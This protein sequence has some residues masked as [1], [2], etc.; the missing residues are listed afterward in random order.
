MKN[1]VDVLLN[2]EEFG[3]ISSAVGKGKKQYVLG[4]SSTQKAFYLAGIIKACNK[5]MFVVCENQTAQEKL[6]ADL[7]SFLDQNK[8]FSL[9]NLD[10]LPYGDVGIGADL[11]VARAKAIKAI[12]DEEVGIVVTCCRALMDR[13]APKEVLAAN[14]V[15]LKVGDEVD[16]TKLTMKLSKAGYER[17]QKAEGRGQMSVKGG[18]LDV[19]SQDSDA[20][21]RIE[22]Y[23]DEI[24][25]IR[26]YDKDTQRSLGNLEVAQIFLAREFIYDIDSATKAASSIKDELRNIDNGHISLRV[27]YAIEKM[28]QGIYF[29]N[30]YQYISSI[31]DK[32][33]SI[34]D[35]LS[36][37]TLCVIDEPSKVKNAVIG[38]E[39][40]AIEMYK[41]SIETN[42][43]L[44]SQADSIL[45]SQ[46]ICKR[47]D[48]MIDM[49]F[50][51]FAQGL[52]ESELN[53]ATMVSMKSA[54]S[55]QGNFAKLA[56]DVYSYKKKGYRVL[57]TASTQEKVG[58]ILSELE[59]HVITTTRWNGA[60]I[61]PEASIGAVVAS[62]DEGFVYNAGRLVILSEKEIFG[63]AK[64]VR[65]TFSSGES[66]KITSYMDLSVDDYV[67]HV[68]HGIARY[69]G[70][71]T[72]EIAGVHRDYLI[73]RYA[74]E[75]KVF[76]PT[77]Q[78]ELLQ[79]YIGSKDAP[80]KINRLNGTEWN[81]AKA[82][83]KE[84]IQDMAKG[85][86]EL[87]AEREK[88]KGYAF[89][90]DT[91]WQREFEDRFPY[92]E[93][94]D[95][96]RS[97]SEI[98]RD[99][100]TPRPMDRL[101]CGDVGFGKTEVAMRAAFKAAA[102]GKQ[103][104]L[105]VPTTIL[106]QQH[107]SNF[108]DRF[109]GFPMNVA[110]VSRFQSNVTNKRILEDVK[111]GIIDVLIGTH[112]LLS[113]DVEFKN[114]GLLIVDEEQRFGVSQKE[115]LKE[116]RKEVDVLTLSA[117]PIPRTLHMAM[118]SV[119]DMSLIETP[120][121]NRFPIRTHV[122]EYDSDLLR[123]VIMKEVDRD[124]Q[125]YFVHNK[126]KDLD[127]IVA[128]IRDIVPDV[129]VRAAHGQMSE[130]LLERTMMSFLN[131]EFQI[132]V[133]TTIIES[134][135][136]I[137]NVNT[138]IINEAQNLGLAQLYQLKGRVGRA[139]RIA[140]AYLM[141]KKDKVMT[142]IAEKR[143][144]AI[145]EFTNLG[146]GYKI[147]MR[148]MEIR[149]VGNILGPEQHGHIASIGFEMYCRLLEETMSEIRGEQQKSELAPIL[150]D[151][152]VDAFIPDSYISDSREKIDMYRKINSIETNDD[153]MDIQDEMIDRFGNMPS[154]VVNLV[155]VANIKN[156]ARALGFGQVS[157]EKGI[158]SM[159]FADG[160]RIDIDAIA[161]A[162]KKARA[163]SQM[164]LGREGR[165][166][167][168]KLRVEVIEEKDILKL[169]TD[170]L[171]ALVV[172]KNRANTRQY[173]V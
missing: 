95:Q 170:V 24:E 121:E 164:I 10:L 129:K 60:E 55:Y 44:P 103:V 120:P 165:V 118:V 154:S 89:G 80:P 38:R 144:A 152:A 57:C 36:K 18:I 99:M 61:Q 166:L 169:I 8:V 40:D 50:S 28:E 11:A 58:N 64:K 148:D 128:T 47:L 14:I 78:V 163:K 126:V 156:M 117:T 150:I 9:P 27:N 159:R 59:E 94:P 124:G 145:R 13:L 42:M 48:N 137:P 31:Y 111:K 119:R 17:L 23:G 102:D 139:N 70:L 77:D 34:L 130:D 143:L 101:L 149:G 81:R 161:V 125:V 146:S 74:G 30:D 91:V 53:A 56:K 7:S 86:L 33:V 43:I 172:E 107:F 171:N 12:L 140:Y 131:K 151:I 79:K 112:R 98:K 136:D 88:I 141:F 72:M 69:E 84:S 153:M 104:A 82:K 109:E 45:S 133:C 62:I 16:L 97:I 54:D 93:T 26:L 115:K 67:V 19:F 52:S 4:L 135:I 155:S 39:K 2:V 37:D 15:E 116:L 71:K 76:V 134:G 63:R 75:D 105:L 142:D 123:E 1:V 21:I 168:I 68:N 162:I 51:L 108:S 83:V 138:I 132:L 110:V 158:V 100:E 35:Y 3:R 167:G 22:F 87:Y 92:Q 173:Y 122:V 49:G 20:P 32:R 157:L 85:L 25:S 29:E 127:E 66:T 147:A 41:E 65:R 6:V 96:L 5:P 90:S 106:A 114:L 160:M 46:E 113:K 73:L